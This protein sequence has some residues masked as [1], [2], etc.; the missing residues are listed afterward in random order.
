[1]VVRI[2]FSLTSLALGSLLKRRDPEQGIA[3]YWTKSSTLSHLFAQGLKSAQAFRDMRFRELASAIC[4]ATHRFVFQG[5]PRISDHTVTYANIT[6]AEGNLREAL[7]FFSKPSLA[8][9]ARKLLDMRY[10][11]R[12]KKI[13]VKADAE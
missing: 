2:E 4:P 6:Q 1:M 13:P 10:Q 5:E 7:P 9:P 3:R 8:N 12:L 11:V